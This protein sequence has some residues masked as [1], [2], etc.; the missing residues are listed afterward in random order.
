MKWPIPIQTPQTKKR[1]RGV[2]SLERSVAKQFATVGLN[3]VLG[4]TNLTLGPT[5]SHINNQVQ[6]AWW[7][8][9]NPPISST[10]LYAKT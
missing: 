5:G 2:T 1:T 10:M 9:S 6:G 3:Q 8:N 4:C 7:N